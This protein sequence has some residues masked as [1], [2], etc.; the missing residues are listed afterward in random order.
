MAVLTDAAADQGRARRR[1]RR[2]GGRLGV[3][4]NVRA[5]GW[6]LMG[7]ADTNGA[8][9]HAAYDGCSEP[10][11]PGTVELIRRI[12]QLKTQGLGDILLV[13]GN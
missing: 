13:Q 6:R 1:R 11:D 12:G 8:T 2:R 10:D 9:I 4:A 7:I 5:D 3:T